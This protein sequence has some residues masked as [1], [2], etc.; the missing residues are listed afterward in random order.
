MVFDVRFGPGLIEPE[1]APRTTL[2]WEQGAARHSNDHLERLRRGCA[3]LGEPEAWLDQA[4]AQAYQW[5]KDQSVDAPALAL[6][7]VADPRSATL[8]VRLESLPAVV[9]P[10]TLHP[11]AHP[12]TEACRGPLAA[13]KGCLGPWHRQA[14]AEARACGASDAL[15]LDSDRFLV[16][17]AIAAIGRLEGRRLTTPPPAGRVRSIAELRDL[18]RWADERGWELISAPISLQEARLGQ[19]WCFN[20]L[21]GLWPA[22]C[23]LS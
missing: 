9:Q 21:R 13:H 22:E 20:A 5:A 15:L 23:H 3:A 4:L 17:S 6:R 7:L 11:M 16:E 10:Y 12:L 19:L 14:L 1:T 8:F 18:P 2:R